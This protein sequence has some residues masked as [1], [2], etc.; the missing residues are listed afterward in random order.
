M[1]PKS[2]APKIGS[3]LVVVLDLGSVVSLRRLVYIK[4]ALPLP[5][6]GSQPQTYFRTWY[7][8]GFLQNVQHLAILHDELFSSVVLFIIHHHPILSRR[9]GE[10][11]AYQDQLHS[12]E[13][14][15]HAGHLHSTT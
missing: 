11:E 9:S 8:V 14:T 7:R 2:L 15:G 4:K 5:N 13:C 1:H 12:V 3:T 10:L 6:V